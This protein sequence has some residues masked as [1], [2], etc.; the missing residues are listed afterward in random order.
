M[1]SESERNTHCR[2]DT[3]Q[4]ERQPHVTETT[5]RAVV[6]GRVITERHKLI[7]VLRNR[8]LR[9]L[10]RIRGTAEQ[11]Q[12]FIW[13][14][15]ARY[16]EGFFDKTR[17]RATGWQIPQP[18]VIDGAGESVRLDD[19]LV[20][21][22]AVLHTQVR[23]RGADRWARLGVPVLKISGP[24]EGAADLQDSDGSLTRWLRA[25]KVSSV[26]V[27]PDGFIYAAA[28]AGQILASPPF[29]VTARIPQPQ[30]IA[31]TTGATA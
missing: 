30:Q 12:R 31:S 11:L 5:R 8:S 20:G 7:A 25:K 19:V 24:G 17:S 4:M 6:V 14:P 10:T 21:Q 13:I 28:G 1:R 2:I 27:R 3:Y 15:P 23:P 16:A 22:W 26:A 29:E 18:W 9:A